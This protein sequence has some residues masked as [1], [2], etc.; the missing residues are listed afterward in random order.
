MRRISIDER[1]RFTIQFHLPD[2]L[3]C[4]QVQFLFWFSGLFGYVNERPVLIRQSANLIH[5]CNVLTG[6][7]LCSFQRFPQ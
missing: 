7:R 6:I 4:N 3:L 5:E 2:K 1:P